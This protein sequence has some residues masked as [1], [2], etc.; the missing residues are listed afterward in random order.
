M[1]RGTLVLRLW[2]GRFMRAGRDIR[3]ARLDDDTALLEWWTRDDALGG[4]RI[5]TLDELD[6]IPG[7]IEKLKVGYDGWRDL[8]EGTD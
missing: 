7:H 3:L 2:N 1:R 8:T 4:E 6:L 5:Y